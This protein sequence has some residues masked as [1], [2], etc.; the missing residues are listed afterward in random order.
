MK[1][2]YIAIGFGTITA[3]QFVLGIYMVTLAR[4][5]GGKDGTLY[6]KSLSFSVYA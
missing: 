2:V 3:S 6:W 1:N 5:E 4:R